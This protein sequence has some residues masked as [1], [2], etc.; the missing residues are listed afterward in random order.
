MPPVRRVTLPPGPPVRRELVESIWA[1][2][3]QRGL[4]RSVPFALNVRETGDLRGQCAACGSGSAELRMVQVQ[5]VNV[6]YRQK[7]MGCLGFCTFH[8]YIGHA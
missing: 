8:G 3:S 6:A 7:A 1:V 5:R 2:P 4:W